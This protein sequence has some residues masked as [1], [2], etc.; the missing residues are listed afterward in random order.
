MKR[1]FK[2]HFF[3][4]LL[5]NLRTKFQTCLRNI[6]HTSVKKYSFLSLCFKFLG[7]NKREQIKSIKKILLRRQSLF[8]ESLFSSILKDILISAKFNEM[9][10]LKSKQ[11]L[12]I[13]NY[14]L[15]MYFTAS[16]K[17][18]NKIGI[19]QNVKSRT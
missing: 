1:Y 10:I 14:I 3:E 7:K 15:S 17:L 13:I 12:E 4:R 8:L 19:L 16:K 5:P 6:K 2:W 18:K 9:L 11:N